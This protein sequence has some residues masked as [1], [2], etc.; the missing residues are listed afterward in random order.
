VFHGSLGPVPDSLPLV[1]ARTL[2]WCALK[3]LMG[4]K[5]T[6]AEWSP[7]CYVLLLCSAGWRGW[8]CMRR[9]LR[10]LGRC[11]M[12]LVSIHFFQCKDSWLSVYFQKDLLLL[13]LIL[14]VDL[15]C[16]PPRNFFCELLL[17]ELNGL[18]YY[19]YHFAF[20]SSLCSDPKC[21][22]TCMHTQTHKYT[23][24]N[25][26]TEWERREISSRK[27]EIPISCKD[28]HNKRQKL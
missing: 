27:L 8:T 11:L 10:L 2:C 18:F 16:L 4:G 14:I 25:V 26:T 22:L 24:R 3:T 28:G 6:P 21:I 17:W 9:I 19:H 5:I 7:L 20:N 1:W 13:L 12:F 23:H 15:V